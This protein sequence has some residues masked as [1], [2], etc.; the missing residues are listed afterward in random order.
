[1]KNAMLPNSRGVY[2]LIR[3]I[4]LAPQAHARGI[5]G[6]VQGNCAARVPAGR[7]RRRGAMHLGGHRAGGGRR[8]ASIGGGK[9]VERNGR[10]RRPHST[11]HDVM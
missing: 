6:A 11:L 8:L 3:P 4:P 7:R 2:R 10:C 1:M 9:R 5:R